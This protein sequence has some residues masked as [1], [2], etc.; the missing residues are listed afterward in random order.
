M[1]AYREWR[2]LFRAG[3]LSPIQAA[4]FQPRPAEQ[5]FD[6]E[7][8]PHQ[9]RDL[10]GDAAHQVTLDRM[11]GRLQGRLRAINDLSFFPE[12]EMV[13]A[14]LDDPIAY[15]RR[16]ADAIRR[17]A[18]IADLQRWAFDDARTGLERA[19]S[20]GNP[21][22]RY[23]GCIAATSHGA[24]ANPLIPAVRAL[25]DDPNAMVRVRAAECLG[26]WRAADPMPTLYEVL[27]AVT[28]EQETMMAL[29]AVV[30]LRDHQGWPVDRDQLKLKFTGG[31]TARR[32]EYLNGNL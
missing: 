29:Q 11:R 13:R 25:L 2:E 12:S 3:T 26:T 7:T 16:H 30:Y 17:L 15:G 27:G 1:P 19:L 21:W 31:E 4:F 6:L 28:T 20:S 5:L 23:W 9:V 8:D 14:A 24:G 22:D 18:G 10:A 32:M